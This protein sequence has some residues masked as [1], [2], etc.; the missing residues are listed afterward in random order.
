MTKAIYTV[1]GLGLLFCGCV[2]Q[3]YSFDGTHWASDEVRLSVGES[4]SNWGVTRAT[5]TLVSTSPTDHSARFAIQ[6]PGGMASTQCVYR[7]HEV[8]VGSLC[9]NNWEGYLLLCEVGGD[10][11]VLAWTREVTPDECGINVPR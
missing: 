1:L 6:K 9:Q 3:E 7:G 2:N 11:V 10:S 5:I 8:N 4:L